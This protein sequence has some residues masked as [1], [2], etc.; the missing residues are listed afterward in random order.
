[1]Y[2]QGDGHLCHLES[3]PTA[4]VTDFYHLET[5]VTD[6]IYYFPAQT[7]NRVGIACF[8]CMLSTR[9]EARLLP[10]RYQRAIYRV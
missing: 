8:K 4:W 7:T 10:L 5:N 2:N 3:K 6:E 1:M 9:S